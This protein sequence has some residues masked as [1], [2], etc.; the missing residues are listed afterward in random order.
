LLRKSKLFEDPQEKY[1]KYTI[2]AIYYKE[3]GIFEIR[4]D[5]IPSK[6]RNDDYFYANQVNNILAWLRENLKITLRTLNYKYIIENIK[7]NYG[8]EISSCMVSM[9]TFNKSKA[10]LTAAIGDEPILPIL[11]ELKEVLSENEEIFNEESKARAKLEEF[12]DNIESTSDLPREA[13]FWHDT[14]EITEFIY[15]YK[16]N[17]FCM[18]CYRGR[19]Q[20]AGR[21]E[22]VTRLLIKN[23]KSTE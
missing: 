13:L 19:D 6:Y 1:I 7:K 21:M 15:E 16:G 12:I 20:S 18:L 22:D 3:L 11:G 10:T 5:D 14:K 9:N 2:L 4:I 23:Q 8:G 17:D